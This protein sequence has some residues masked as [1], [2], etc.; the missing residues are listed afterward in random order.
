MVDYAPGMR[1]IIRD[2]EWM[3]RK[4][5]TNSLNHKTLYCIGVSPLVKDH[6]AMFLTDIEDIEQIDPAKVKLVADD[7]PYFRRSRLYIESQCRQKIPTDAKLHIGNLAAMDT[8]G[9]Q[10]ESAQIALRNTRQR[11]LIADA[12]GLGKSSC[13]HL[14]KSP[15]AVASAR[16]TRWPTHHETI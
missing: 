4:V 1:L 5:D 11:I 8:M 12:V 15:Y 6:D 7:S 13:R 10:L 3:V 2:E 9:F 14:P 16:P